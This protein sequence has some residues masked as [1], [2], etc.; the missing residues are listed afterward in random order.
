MIAI[1]ALTERV[2]RRAAVDLDLL[3][4]MLAP[5]LTLAG[6]CLAFSM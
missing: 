4:A 6:F 3:F 2:M 1:V 5:I